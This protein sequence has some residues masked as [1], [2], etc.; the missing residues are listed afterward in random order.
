MAAHMDVVPPYDLSL[1]KVDPFS[2]EIINNKM[3][4]RGTADTKGSLAAMMAATAAVA[5][6]DLDLE[7]DLKLVAWSGD[8]YNPP[9]AKYFNGMSYLALND[10]IKGDAA[11]FGEPYDLKITYLSKGR[12]WFEFEIEGVASHSATGAGVNAIL[13]AIELIEGIYQINVGEHPVTGKDSSEDERNATV[14]GVKTNFP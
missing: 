6:L 3:Y 11:V 9:D 14:K 1:W 4:G 2:G 10:L 8:E 13:K 5:A 7:G 12:I